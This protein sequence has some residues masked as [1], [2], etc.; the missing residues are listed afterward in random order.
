MKKYKAVIEIELEA[1]SWIEATNQLQQLIN[2]DTRLNSSASIKS[3][4]ETMVGLN[5]KP[6][7]QELPPHNKHD[8]TK[9]QKKPSSKITTYKETYKL[10]QQGHTVREIAKQRNLK[11][12]TIENQLIALYTE[13]K[14]VNISRFYNKNNVQQVLDEIEKTGTNDWV[15]LKK[16]LPD[17]ISFTEIKAIAAAH[18]HYAKR[19]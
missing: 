16:N 7:A 5:D 1:P 3:L 8:D 2:T 13:G 18:N 6:V 17:K 19:D 9:V 4:E 14:D 15:L 10:Y 11:E 12:S